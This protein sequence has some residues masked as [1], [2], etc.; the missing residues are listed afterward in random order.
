V[1]DSC[2]ISKP[3]QFYIVSLNGGSFCIL[4]GSA[5]PKPFVSG[6]PFP[7][8]GRGAFTNNAAA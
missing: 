1:T 4:L 2:S 5:R 6:V 8:C 3:A 7:L